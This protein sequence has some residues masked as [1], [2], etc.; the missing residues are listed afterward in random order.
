MIPAGV[1]ERGERKRTAAEA[2]ISSDNWRSF[3]RLARITRELPNV[4]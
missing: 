4:S 2:S 1:V 3:S